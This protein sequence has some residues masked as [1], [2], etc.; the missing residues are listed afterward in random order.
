MPANVES[1]MYAGRVPWHGIGTAVQTEV[2]AANALERAGLNWAVELQPIF[3]GGGLVQVPV[4]CS[5][6]TVRASDQKVLGVVGNRYVP[7][8]NTDAFTFFDELV[9]SGQAI[10]HTAGA[11]DGGRRIWVLAKLPGDLI[12]GGQRDQVERYLLLVNSHDGS[13]ALRMLMTPIRVVCQ[14]TLN[15]ALRQG[16]GEGI[17]IRHTAS[18]TARTDEARRALGIATGYYDEFEAEANL[19]ANARYGDADMR[20]L[21]ETLFPQDADEVSTRTRN[22]R[23]RVTALFTEGLGHAQIRGTAWAALN[24]VAEFTDHHRATR[25]GDLASRNEKRLSS[26]WLGSGAVL[27]RVAY[28]TIVQQIAA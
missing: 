24:A 13:S 21:V 12:V 16:A 27:K 9:G 3:A 8:Q 1:M 10:Y 2:T 15:L 17:A 18:A 6:A 25:S 14:N 11:L 22:L 28:Q 5:R 20:R 23:D 4:D 19:L 26:S 7:V